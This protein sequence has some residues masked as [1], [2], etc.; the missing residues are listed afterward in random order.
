LKRT[1]CGESSPKKSA[2]VACK[3]LER[4]QHEYRS[5]VE[6]KKMVTE[7]GEWQQRLE[8]ARR[9]QRSIVG[10]EWIELGDVKNEGYGK[11]LSP[12]AHATNGL[13]RER[14]TDS[15][16]TIKCFVGG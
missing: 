10:D 14:I 4:F 15:C 2:P 8:I 7:A 9:L 16:I 5:G 6:T 1:C 12:F 11:K 3:K 13:K